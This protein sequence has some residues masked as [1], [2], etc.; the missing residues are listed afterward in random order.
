MLMV[1]MVTLGRTTSRQLI[2]LL[3]VS[4]VSRVR[5]WRMALV[6]VAVGALGYVVV[7]T[8]ASGTAQ[9]VEAEAGQLSVGAIKTAV[10]GA[11]GGY[12]VEF[13]SGAIPTPTPKASPAP[14]GNPRVGF[15]LTHKS[16]DFAG[17]AAAALAVQQL[18]KPTS[19]LLNVSLMGWGED[20]PE[21][22][23]GQYNWSSLDKRIQWIRG[24]GGEAVITLC[25]APD[26]MKGGSAGSTDWDALETAPITSHYDDFANLAK[27]AA[28]RYPD[29]RYFQV[30]NEMKG[31]YLSEPNRWDYENYTVMYNKV[32]T[33]IKS[34]RPDAQIGGPYVSMDSWQYPGASNWAST[35]KGAWGILDERSLDVISY[36]LAHNVGAEF[37][38]IDGGAS[39]RDGGL[40]ESATA[41]ADK[42][43]AVAAWLAARTNLP[44]WWSELYADPGASGTEVNKQA[45]YINA[46][47]KFFS[48]GGDVALLWSEDCGSAAYEYGA[49]WDCSSGAAYPLFH[50]LTSAYP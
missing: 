42:F 1:D 23:P 50:A 36:W 38:A 32:Y 5:A 25:G 48:A 41:S 34:V 28:M 37:V 20:N 18:L 21:P 10:A 12:V 19:K 6:I 16:A 7:R 33:A 31:F 39:T 46:L 35:V 17:S 26:W 40:L 47:N 13:G 9:V 3:V 30:W 14:A 27:V 43:A 2:R 24:A 29:V 22:S 15:T 11:S 45:V 8:L 4:N 44:I 49:A